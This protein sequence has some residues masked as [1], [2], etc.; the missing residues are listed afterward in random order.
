M[1]EIRKSINSI[2]YERATS[3]FFGTLTLSWLV[4]NWR[5]LYLT[6]FIS[7]SQLKVNKID[8][9]TE[10]YSNI[11]QLLTFPLI[12]TIV[13]ITVVPFI[14]N[15]AYWLALRF[16]KWRIDQ[17]NEIEMKQLLTIE[18]SIELR[19]EIRNQQNRFEELLKDKNLE[20]EQLTKALESAN[21][22]P[23]TPPTKSKPT[24][25]SKPKPTEDN[26]AKIQEFFESQYNVEQFKK[27]VW[28]IQNSYKMY[29]VSNSA[30]PSFVSY[31]EANDLIEQN[32]SGKYKFTDE[33]KQYY[34]FYSEL[35]LS[36]K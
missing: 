3:P 33:G 11:H 32:S 36:K 24:P 31:L 35:A 23:S 17:R 30:D 21:N 15:G 10:N 27:V 12:S 16:R 14:S 9:I 29:A 6:F 2:L 19:E 25:K 7:E 13:L 34:K 18:Q 8:F 4:W 28:V 22:Q 20:I 5:I 1:D 26:K